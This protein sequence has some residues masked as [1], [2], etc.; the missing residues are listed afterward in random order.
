MSDSTQKTDDELLDKIKN[1]DNTALNELIIRYRSTVEAIAMKYINSPLEKD[2]L[3]QEGMIGLLAAINSYNSNKG[4]KFVT[5]ASRCINNSVQTALRKFSRLKDIPQSN[6]VAL[7]EDFFEGRVVLSAE[8]EYLA[9]ESVSTL[10]EVLYEGLSSFENEVLRLYIVGCSYAEI[11]QKL[12]K[13]QKSIDN[14]IQRI[15]KKLDGV[16]F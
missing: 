14:A 3:V 15:R 4:A 12:G 11:A 5:Y 7:E 8:D 9:K 2:D 13:N 6:I 1:N 10:T 16:T